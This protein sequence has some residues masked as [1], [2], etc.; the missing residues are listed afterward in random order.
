MKKF[1]I[2]LSLLITTPCGIIL[3]IPYFILT[4]KDL[5]LM[6]IDFYTEKLK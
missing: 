4:G 2:R 1:L 3:C 6:F 5:F